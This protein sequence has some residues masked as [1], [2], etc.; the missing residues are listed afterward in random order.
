MAKDGVQRGERREGEIGPRVP[1]ESVTI[2][3]APEFSAYVRYEMNMQEPTSGE[4]LRAGWYARL[5]VQRVSKD[6]AEQNRAARRVLLRSAP[7]VSGAAFA[8]ANSVASIREGSTNDSLRKSRFRKC[9]RYCSQ[10]GRAFHELLELFVK[11]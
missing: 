8:A 1:T 5:R 4:Y 11:L 2:I 6:E 9:W 3:S 7:A 10:H